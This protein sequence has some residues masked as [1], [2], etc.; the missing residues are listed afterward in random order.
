M[1]HL[2]REFNANAPRL[3][4]GFKDFTA[5]LLSRDFVN[6]RDRN[7]TRPLYNAATAGELVRFTIAP[8]NAIDPNAIGRTVESGVPVSFFNLNSINSTTA[9]N[10]ALAALN[11]LRPD[12]AR[13]ELEQ[14][15]AIGNSF[16][17]GL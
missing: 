12:P 8:L 17:H 5:Y 2:W 1:A 6:F 16:Y 14:L 9:L 10:A 3:P 4:S 11:D 13:T 7:G 15:A